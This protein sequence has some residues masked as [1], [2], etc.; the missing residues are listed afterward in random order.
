MSGMIARFIGWLAKDVIVNGLSNNKTFQ[1]L[2][3]KLEKNINHLN[4]SVE[5]KVVKNG[6]AFYKE[7]S[8][9]MKDPNFN[10]KNFMQQ[11]MD[12]VSKEVNK[13]SQPPTKK[14]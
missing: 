11:F 12:D 8:S 5:E 6:E 9:K 4:K 2:A 3:V 14:R 10:P 13:H 1:A 7:A